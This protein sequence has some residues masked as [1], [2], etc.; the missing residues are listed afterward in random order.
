MAARHLFAAACAAVILIGAVLP[1]T[2]ASYPERNITFLVPFKTGGGYDAT[3]RTVAKVLG[4]YLP[5]EVDVRP[6]NLP[7]G[8]GRKAYTKLYNAKPDGYTIAAFAYPGGAMPQIVGETVGYDFEKLTWLARLSQSAYMV[9]LNKESK[10]GS[11]AD[12]RG[13]ELPVKIASSGLGSTSFAVTAIFAKAVGFKMA[14]VTGYE[15]SREYTLGVLRGDA[16]MVIGTVE[17]LSRFVESG[18]LKP[19]ITFEAKPTIPGLLT[20]REAGFPELEGMGAQRLVAA[21]PTLPDDIR[22]ILSDAIQKAIS[23]PDSQAWAEKANRPFDPLDGT[24]V[25]REVSKGSFILKRYIE[26]VGKD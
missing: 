2:A 26:A 10:I 12:L 15:G 17:G 21:P 8:G 3:V 7:G 23:D 9:A 16:E 22:Q 11:L 13:R 25:E 18:D 1:A 19:L 5:N 4:K 14:R 6:L 20:V 24:A